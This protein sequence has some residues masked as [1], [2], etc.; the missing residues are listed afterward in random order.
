MNLNNFF[1]VK[2]E[3][4]LKKVEELKLKLMKEEKLDEKTAL[5][6]AEL[7]IYKPEKLEKQNLKG[8]VTV[9]YR[10]GVTFYFD[11]NEPIEMIEKLFHLHKKLMS[12]NDSTLLVELLKEKL[13]NE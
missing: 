5:H 10:V 8:D 12:V 7:Q 4:K 3:D 2:K 1:D 9:G 11:D 6:K 13:N